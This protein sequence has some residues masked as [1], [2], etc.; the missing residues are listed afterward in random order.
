MLHGAGCASFGISDNRF[1]LEN[2]VRKLDE[3]MGVNLGYRQR[4]D[5]VSACGQ[6]LDQSPTDDGPKGAAQMDFR[7][8]FADAVSIQSLVFSLE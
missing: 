4:D 1:D 3:K 6:S 5:F 2:V 7:A 8:R